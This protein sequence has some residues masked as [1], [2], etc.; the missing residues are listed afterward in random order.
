MKINYK[1]KKLEKQLTLPK[2]MQKA[3]GTM[4]KKVNQRMKELKAAE[5]LEVMKTISAAKCHELKNDR[6]GQLAVAISGN[7]RIIFG[8][9]HD[10]V[11]VN[12][13][14]GMDW[15]SITIIAI[16]EIVDYH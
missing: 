1:T 8:P 4:A 3:F 14:G 12:E 11:P 7:Y 16:Q 13:D 15:Q 2:E 6:K 10:P 9:D 5:H